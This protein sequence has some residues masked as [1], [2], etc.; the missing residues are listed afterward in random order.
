MCVKFLIKTTLSW[1]DRR[2]LLQLRCKQN[3]IKIRNFKY[4]A[5]LSMLTSPPMTIAVLCS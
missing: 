1:L 2:E 5:S 3:Q 4:G